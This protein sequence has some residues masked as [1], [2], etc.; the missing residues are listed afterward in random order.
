MAKTA[1]A[2]KAPVKA[3][4]TMIPQYMISQY[5][6]GNFSR[7]KLAKLLKVTHSAIDRALL[8]QGVRK[9]KTNARPRDPE[10]VKR[11]ARVVELHRQGNGY[12]KVAEMITAETGKRIGR[13][14]VEQIVRAYNYE[15]VAE[16]E[17]PEE[18]NLNPI[19]PVSDVQQPKKLKG[20]FKSPHS[21]I[22]HEE[23]IPDEAIAAAEEVEA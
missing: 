15:H 23:F 13:H 19:C 21:V 14:R 20:K 18:K 1:K 5:L 10:I 4:G 8:K 6:K 7:E 17:K 3:K 22:V 16:A 2:A 11:D 9:P 12:E